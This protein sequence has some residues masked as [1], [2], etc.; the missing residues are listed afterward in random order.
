MPAQLARPSL[1][2]HSRRLHWQRR[3]GIRLRP[4]RIKRAGARKPGHSDL[5]F[6]FG[7]IRFE[8]RVSNRPI[9]KARARYRTD[10]AALNEIDLVKSPEI[11]RKV[12]ARTADASAISQRSLGPAFLVRRLAK[13]VRLQLRMIGEL[14]LRKDLDF[15]VCEI[16]FR[17]IGALLQHHHAKPVRRKFL[18]QDSS[19]GA[20]ANDHEIHF[21]G[22][23][24]LRL[25]HSHFFSASF[26]AASQPG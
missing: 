11:R 6:H 18:G 25:V 10:F 4:W 3:H 13:R 2:N 12:H 20:G 16:R 5:P 23:L 24:I 1:E 21:V 9:R 26:I 15:A 8:V 7:V 22:S 17:Q 19:G 14:I